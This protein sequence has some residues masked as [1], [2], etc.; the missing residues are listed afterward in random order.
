MFTKILKYDLRRGNSVKKYLLTATVSILF[1]LDYYIKYVRLASFH[2]VSERPGV[3]EY[4][5]Y[6]FAG[7][8]R[9]ETFNALWVLVFIFI[10]FINLYYP[11]ND[12]AS[13]G[14]QVLIKGRSR[15]VWWYSKCCWAVM[16][17]AVVNIIIFLSAIV[18]SIITRS[19]FTPEVSDLCINIARRR[20]SDIPTGETLRLGV[21]LLLLP[22]FTSCALCLVQMAL[23]LVLRPNVSFMISTAYIIACTF[24]QTP[25]LF[26]NYSVF[27]RSRTVIEDGLSPL[28]GII[29]A[30]VISIA[31][32]AAGS[33]IFSRYDILSKE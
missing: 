5:F 4:I 31:A 7:N 20:Y 29:A 18:F 6:I 24:Y 25:F 16:S 10:A 22:F 11:F 8:E 30:S 32:A 3:L 9:F 2:G 23:S 19:R 1:C 28:T 14:S 17:C 27:L 21:Q 26:L 33:I 12:L 15:R 13:F